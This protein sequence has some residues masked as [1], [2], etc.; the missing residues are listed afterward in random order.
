MDEQE[1]DFF[2][3]DSVLNKVLARVGL[4]QCDQKML[5]I[6]TDIHWCHDFSDFLRLIFIRLF[7]HSFVYLISIRR[8]GEM[9]QWLKILAS[10]F[11]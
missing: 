11:L 8:A 10:F 5:V 6:M 1:L 2:N 4:D 3:S 9:D 7:V